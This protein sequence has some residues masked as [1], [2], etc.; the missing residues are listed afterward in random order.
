MA[1]RA[2]I[3]LRISSDPSGNRLGVSRQLK[4]CQEKALAKGWSVTKTYE[5]NDISAFS[6]KRRPAYEQ[7]LQDLESGEIDAVIVWD[8]DR[9]TRRPVEM[10]AFIALADRRGVALATVGG[11]ADLSTDNGRLFARI[12]GAVARAEIERKSIRQQAAND[13]RAAAGRPHAGRRAY[14]YS[15][16]GMEVL[17]TEAAE[18]RKAIENLLAGR[19]VRSIVAEMNSRGARTTAGNPWKPTELRRLLQN[20]RHAGLRVHRGEVV[21]KGVW[22]AI[23]DEDSHRAVCAILRDPSRR[24][25]GPPRRHLLSGLATCGVCGGTIYGV[26]EPRGAVY[27]CE[28]R[29]HVARRAERVD[30]LVQEVVVSRLSRPDAVAELSRTRHLDQAAPLL[31]EERQ[32][33]AKLDGLAEAF[34]A[35][36]IDRQQLR[37]GSRRLQARLAA[38]TESLAA[39]AGTTVVTNLVAAGDIEAAWERLDVASRREVVGALLSVTLRSPGRGARNFDP[40]TVELRWL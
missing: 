18:F 19:S 34:A 16:E 26:S 14:G 25:A 10:E 22:P 17:P 15:P 32:L 7:M 4:D 28:S 36:D 31:Q 2:G 20:P 33:R 39:S 5:D 1:N 30:R 27:Y 37:A 3:Y 40:K 12:K 13:Q 24:K 9:L 38:V 8:L 29:K 6:G 11:D 23:I 35:G 21:G